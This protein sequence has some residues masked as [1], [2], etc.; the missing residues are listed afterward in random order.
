MDLRSF[1]VYDFP[2]TTSYVL[3][4]LL[5]SFTVAGLSDLRRMSAQRE[6]LEIWAIVVAALLG[7]DLWQW[8]TASPDLR[9][10]LGAKWALVVLVALLSWRRTRALFRLAAGDVWAVAAVAATLNPLFIVAFVLLLWLANV[11][12]RPALAPFGEGGAYPFIPVVV[13]ATVATAALILTHAGDRL[14]A[15]FA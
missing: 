2:P 9:F 12:L 4:F 14:A 15:A 6:F 13:A 3:V 11:A 1:L 5:G 7:I 8:R 10:L